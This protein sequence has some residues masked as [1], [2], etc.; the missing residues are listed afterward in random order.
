[1]SGLSTLAGGPSA[2][3]VERVRDARPELPLV[4]L[5]LLLL[6]LGPP[7]IRFGGRH[8]TASMEGDQD[9]WNYLRLAWWAFWGV[10]ILVDLIR[11]NGAVRSL[12][13]RLGAAPLFVALWLTALFA[14]CWV[15]PA[16]VYSG[17]MTLMTLVLVLGAVDLATKLHV[18]AVS[19]HRVYRLVFGLGLGLLILV[20]VLYKTAPGSNVVQGA[21]YGDR[22]R[23]GTVAYTPLLSSIMIL[24]ALY[25]MGTARSAR[26]RFGYLAALLFGAE[27]LHLGQTRSSY[28][29]FLLAAS[30]YL[31]DWWRRRRNAILLP[32]LLAAFFMT[33]FA[34]TVAYEVS[35]GARNRLDYYYNRYVLRDQH[36][37]A[38]PDFA[39]ENL[40]SLNGRA[41]VFVLL[42]ENAF[43][44]PLGLG[45]IAG[46]RRFLS[47]NIVGLPG[48]HN[49][50]TEVWGGSGL[51]GFIGFAGLVLLVAWKSRQLR[52]PQAL[53]IRALLPLILVEGMF[54]SD[55]V[56]PFVQSS[57]FFWITSAVIAGLWVRETDSSEA[58]AHTRG[59]RTWTPAR[60][61]LASIEF[62]QREARPRGSW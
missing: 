59:L 50:Y 57:A 47:E 16:P 7:A 52:S 49:A 45:F 41:E 48:A 35:D 11:A 61:R 22:V 4:R 44:E 30:V 39:R 1:M 3:P 38:N 58:L 17:F 21:F 10:V 34:A 15:S 54:E 8:A 53:L 31:F 14:S 32:S 26:A 13:K 24:S 2:A 55:M 18:G 6:F 9:I 56:F 46:P 40:G 43:F 12:V 29:G 62:P 33:V 20:F 27:M 28:V 23:G 19:V 42:S 60:A 51:G 25:L 5:P 37:I 36:N